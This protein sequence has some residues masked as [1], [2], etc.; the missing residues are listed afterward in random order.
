MVRYIFHRKLSLAS[1]R[2]PFVL[3]ECHEIPVVPFLYLVLGP[4]RVAAHR[5]VDISLYNLLPTSTSPHRPSSQKTSEQTKTPREE[6]PFKVARK[7]FV[8]RH[9]GAKTNLLSLRISHDQFFSDS[10][11]LYKDPEHCTKLQE[12]QNRLWRGAGEYRA[13]QSAL[14]PCPS[15]GLGTNGFC[16]CRL[17]DLSKKYSS[18]LHSVCKGPHQVFTEKQCTFLITVSSRAPALLGRNFSTWLLQIVFCQ[19]GHKSTDS[20]LAILTKVST[21]RS[22][23]KTLFLGV[24][25]IKTLAKRKAP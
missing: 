21:W 16:C 3:V 2:F 25:R 14:D 5:K 18:E 20:D 6:G 8:R 15:W 24:A 9:E 10:P 17:G 19:T 13:L 22:Q 12:Q 11:D 7:C 4:S 23:V 1:P